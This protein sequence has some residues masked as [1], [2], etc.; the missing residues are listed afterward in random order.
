MSPL[1]A[2][3][4]AMIKNTGYSFAFFLL[5]LSVLSLAATAQHVLAQKDLFSSDPSSS[6]LVPTQEMISQSSD[7]SAE[8]EPAISATDAALRA[9]QHVS[10]K[11]MNVRQFQ[12]ENKTYYGVKLLQQNG[13][14]K[15][16]N[17]DANNGSIVE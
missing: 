15:T 8:V 12:D 16:I 7:D 6:T 14:I 11:V 10:G 9:Q 17:I 5:L 1:A 4:R 3:K 13:R 2:I